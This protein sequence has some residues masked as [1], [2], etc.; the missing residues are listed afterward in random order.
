M[1]N[2]VLLFCLLL[3]TLPYNLKAQAELLFGLGEMLDSYD[4]NHNKGKVYIPSELKPEMTIESAKQEI[5]KGLKLTFVAWEYDDFGYFD[6][7]TKIKG[8]RI[9]KNPIVV[10]D[11]YFEF[12]TSKEGVIRINFIDIMFDQ[13]IHD[14]PMGKEGHQCTLKI[15]RHNFAVCN[16]AFADALFYMQR[17]FCIKYS[18]EELEAFKSKA[19]QYLQLEQKPV[20]TEKQRKLFVQ[21]NT[22]LEAKNPR[23]AIDLYIKAYKIDQLAYPE[24]Y[25]N[26][27]LVAG[28]MKNY[29]YAILCMKKY[30]LLLPDAEDAQEARDKIYS[31]EILLQ[32]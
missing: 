29:P 5:I 9:K 27:A 7:S 19:S 28:I 23:K 32:S 17:K 16:P 4:P 10:T 18:A 8:N 12:T 1:K 26:L 20:I 11:D 25:Y 22:M 6:D 30:L 14:T 21:G 3:S 13:V 2:F 24:G 15:G 31:W